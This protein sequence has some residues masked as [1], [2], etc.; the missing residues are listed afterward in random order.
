MTGEF[1]VIHDSY[2]L[3]QSLES[4]AQFG[5]CWVK[6]AVSGWHRPPLQPAYVVTV[7]VTTKVLVDN[8]V[9]GPV[10]CEHGD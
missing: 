6:E 8:P 4:M 7:S 2:R 3:T 1:A 9:G 5:G 10:E